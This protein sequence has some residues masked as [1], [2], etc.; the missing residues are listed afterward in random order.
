[1]ELDSFVQQQFRYKAC[2]DF[3]T[4]TPAFGRERDE[5]HKRSK[6]VGYIQEEIEKLTLV[7]MME[8]R[9]I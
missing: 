3:I 8:A 2:I 4:H 6:Y 5:T 7:Q 9:W 1:M